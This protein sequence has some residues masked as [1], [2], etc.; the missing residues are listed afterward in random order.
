MRKFK[1]I[2]VGDIIMYD[3][4]QIHGNHRFN[5]IYIESVEN[6]DEFKTKTNPKGVIA[7]GK[8]FNTPGVTIRCSEEGFLKY[9]L[10]GDEEKIHIP[11]KNATRIIIR[12]HG[13]LVL[14][15]TVAGKEKE[16]TNQIIGNCVVSDSSR[17]LQ[18][19]M[20]GRDESC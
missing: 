7:Y 15:Y 4:N 13:G 1:D 14:A 18:W 5:Y 16:M 20:E 19:S 17:L 9:A 6:S 8:I 2:E 10:D 11:L 12:E 3:D